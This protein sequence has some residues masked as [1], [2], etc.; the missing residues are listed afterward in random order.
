MRVVVLCGTVAIAMTLRFI[1]H[2][3]QG[4]A[5]AYGAALW[6]LGNILVFLAARSVIPLILAHTFFDFILAGGLWDSD[7]ALPILALL[8]IA[9][10]VILA[11][12]RR[13]EART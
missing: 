8:A 12:Q 6:S 5:E 9:S 3:Y 11:R 7:W 10:G 13:N 1:L 4:P 2:A